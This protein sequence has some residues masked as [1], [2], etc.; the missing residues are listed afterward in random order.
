[1]FQVQPLQETLSLALASLASTLLVQHLFL[2]PQLQAMHRRQFTTVTGT[3]VTGTTAN[4]ATVSGTTVTGTTAN[5]TTVSGTT[6]T[7][8]TAN[9]TNITG[10]T[11]E[12]TTPSGATP[13]IVCSGVV[14]GDATGFRIQGPLI[15]LP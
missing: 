13:A 5:F 2:V 4:F 14:S 6:V 15:I 12:V 1:V 9:F 10:V 7:G 3:T 11:L 8:E